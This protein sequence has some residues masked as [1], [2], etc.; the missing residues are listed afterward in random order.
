MLF[1]V[2]VMSASHGGLSIAYFVCAVEGLG[3]GNENPL[4]TSLRR[5]ALGQIQPSSLHS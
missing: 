4:P 1:V 5:S 2:A 3:G